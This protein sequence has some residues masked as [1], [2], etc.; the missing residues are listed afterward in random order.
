MHCIKLQLYYTQSVLLRSF[1]PV[2]TL[3][4]FESSLQLLLGAFLVRGQHDDAQCRGG[5]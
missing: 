2:H 4:A 5:I 3:S 1:F